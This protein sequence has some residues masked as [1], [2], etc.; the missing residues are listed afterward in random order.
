MKKF[1]LSKE[2]LEKRAQKK[3]FVLRLDVL[4]SY[5]QHAMSVEDYFEFTSQFPDEADKLILD[6]MY[7]GDWYSALYNSEFLP[8]RKGGLFN[9]FTDAG[10]EALGEWV[11]IIQAKQKECWLSY[12]ISEVLIGEDENPSYAFHEHPEWYIPA[13]GRQMLNLSMPEVRRQKLEV[14][15]EVMRKFPLDGLDIDFERHTPILPVGHQWEMREHVTE[16]MREIRK[17]LLQ[18]SKEKNR[19]VMLSARVPDCLK[20]CKEDGLDI[21]TWIEE[22]LVDCITMGSRSFDVKVEEV[23]ALSK[24]I[25]L[26]A[27]YDPHHTVDGYT[28]PLIE[29]I[30]GI[31]YSHLQRGAD[32]VEYFNWTGEGKKE[33]VA[34]YVEKYNMDKAMNGFVEWSNDDFTGINDREFLSKQ[35]KTYVIDRKGGYPWGIGY[36][37]LNADRQLPCVIEGEGEVRLYVAENAGEAKTATLKLLFEELTE[38]PKVYLNGRELVFTAKPH[39]DLQVTT[40]EEAPIS[41]YTV[42]NRLLQGIDLSK[43]CTMLTC[44]LTGMET[45]IGYNEIRVITTKSTRL[46]KVEL[47]VKKK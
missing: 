10:V 12:R 3:S 35:D 45:K 15:A 21:W 16:F 23:R 27:C 39:R 17:E 42:T 41:G 19:V 36:A 25:Q 20:G 9:R 13:F 5:L 29:T 6:C 40:E 2:H 47:E 30:R 26:Y 7:S 28:F 1:V 31:C 32:A 44:D 8:H 4:G 14:I 43:P 24:D 11:K 18:I 46:E 34:H 38:T 22:D 33:L 37:N